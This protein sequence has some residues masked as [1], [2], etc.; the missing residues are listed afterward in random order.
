MPSRESYSAQ[1]WQLEV[2]TF[3][4]STGSFS[5]ILQMILA[6]TFTELVAQLAVKEVRDMLWWFFDR[7]NLDF[8]G[9]WSRRRC[10]ST[11]LTSRGLKLQIFSCRWENRRSQVY[12]LILNTHFKPFY[13]WKIWFRRIISSINRVKMRSNHS[14]A[15]TIR[16]SSKAS[17]VW[18]SWTCSK[19]QKALASHSH[20]LLIWVSF[21][22]FF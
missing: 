10:H 12:N 1:M 18:R 16:I 15:L 2:S 14:F 6:S 3:H 11:N 21:S 22:S 8:C 20:Q 5:M 9:I 19:L 17:S 4:Q 13:S 7:K